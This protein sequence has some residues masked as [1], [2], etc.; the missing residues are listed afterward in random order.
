MRA[1]RTSVATA[2]CCARAWWVG[3]ELP[4]LDVAEVAVEP[5]DLLILATDG[6]RP[7]FAPDPRLREPPEV[8]ADRILAEYARDTD[9]GLVLV[10]RY[11][12]R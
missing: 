5:G 11:H 1:R 6:I 10:A 8:L 12:G 4:S 7:D 9:D 2:C 3:H